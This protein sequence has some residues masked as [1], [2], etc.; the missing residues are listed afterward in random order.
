MI[1]NSNKV[2]KPSRKY[3]KSR[4]VTP[5]SMLVDS[6]NNTKITSN[7]ETIKP[8]STSTSTDNKISKTQKQKQ[9]KKERMLLLQQQQRLLAEQQLQLQQK[10]QLLIQQQQELECSMDV[11]DDSNK[12]GKPSAPITPTALAAKPVKQV[13]APIKPTTTTTTTTP[14][15]CSKKITKNYSASNNKAQLDQSI[16]ANPVK[17]AILKINEENYYLKL[18]VIKLVSDLKSLRNEVLSNPSDIKQ[19]SNKTAEFL[20]PSVRNSKKIV[21]SESETKQIPLVSNDSTITSNK[22]E[23]I[24]STG[25]E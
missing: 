18:E 4:S 8:I 19:E 1:S 2:S 6:I 7:S 10:Q 14:A 21:K 15:V 25:F 3:N 11:E 9:T 20:K 12:I 24:E 13:K 17:Q 16:I 5:D 23:N 22:N